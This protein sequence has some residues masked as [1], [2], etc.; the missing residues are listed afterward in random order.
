[1]AMEAGPG[2]GPRTRVFGGRDAA[3]AGYYAFD[4]AF[5]GGVLVGGG[6]GVVSV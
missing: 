1:M 4:P 6:D 5:L 2:G 3:A